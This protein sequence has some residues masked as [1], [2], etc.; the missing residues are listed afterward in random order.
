MKYKIELALVNW[1]DFKY[2]NPNQLFKY[3]CPFMKAIPMFTVISVDSIVEPVH[4]ISRFER[5]NEY[6]INTFIF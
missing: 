1:Y 5:I 2:S 4:V 6:F 3:D